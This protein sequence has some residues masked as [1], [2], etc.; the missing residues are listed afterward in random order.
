[1]LQVI[2]TFKSVQGES[3]HAG[4]V[5]FFIRLAGCNLR[6]NYCD[7]TYAWTGGEMRSVD[8]LVSLALEANCNT[9][10]ITGGEPLMQ[11]ETPLLAEKLLDAGKTVLIETNGSL[12]FS[13]ISNR[14]CRIVDCKLPGS[15]MAEKNCYAAYDHL[16][17]RDEVKFV[18][19]S[20]EDFDFAL[21]IIRKYDLTGKTG[22]LLFSPV[23]NRVEPAQLAQWVVDCGLPVRMQIQMHKVLWGDKRGV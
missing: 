12:D 19:S 2:E 22:N 10:E 5:C 21:D 18:V 23:W 14:C 20:R 8:E 15:G 11:A 17:G 16:T 6:C 4:K 3:T 9:V 13:V 1:M 7:T